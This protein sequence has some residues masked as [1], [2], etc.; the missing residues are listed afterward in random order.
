[1]KRQRNGSQV[2]QLTEFGDGE[3]AIELMH[4]ISF[5]C[6]KRGSPLAAP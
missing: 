4:K 5:V 3:R 6:R 1:M 2:I